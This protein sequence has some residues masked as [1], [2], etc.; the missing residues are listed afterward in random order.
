MKPCLQC[1][2]PTDGTYC[3]GCRRAR[4]RDRNKQRL[5]Y[6]GAWPATRRAAYPPPGSPC[7]ICSVPMIRSQTARNGM[8]LD[9]EHAQVECRSCNSSH[10]RNA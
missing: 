10:R 3:L 9:H 6:A 7:P 2:V 1:A 8:T 4:D 5:Q